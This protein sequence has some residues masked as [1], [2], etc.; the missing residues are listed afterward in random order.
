MAMV[1]K[2]KN[3]AWVLCW[4]QSLLEVHV[5]AKM[6]V[7]MNIDYHNQTQLLTSMLGGK[8]QSYATQRDIIDLLL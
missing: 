1:K 4:L 5:A 6:K 2:V 7:F 8:R 3:I